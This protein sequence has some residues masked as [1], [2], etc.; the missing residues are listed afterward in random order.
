MRIPFVV[1]NTDTPSGGTLYDLRIDKA[2]TRTRTVP[3]PGT[4]PRP[5]PAAVRS[6]ERVL[7]AVPDGAPVLIDGLVACGVPEVVVARTRRL[8]VVVVVHL[9]L[10]R[11]SGLPADEARDLDA[12]ERRVLRACAGVV[13]TGAWAA[14]HLREHHDLRT[15]HV[16]PPGVDAAS[17]AGGG[18]PRP[19]GSAS[20][21]RLSCVASLTPR[22]GH[23]V[24]FQ[25]LE[26][27][28]DLDWTCVCVGPGTPLTPAPERVRFTGPLHGSDLDAAY[29]RTDLLVLPSLAETYGMVVTEA[30]ARG[31][32]VVASAV[33]GVPEALGQTPDHGVPG[34][35]VPAG[36]PEALSGALRAWLTD[37][38]LRRRLRV[39]AHARRAG[40]ADWSEAARALEE[41]LDR[42]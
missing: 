7:D 19:E 40:L 18:R 25:A 5:D 28:A 35:L 36:D 13:A 31:I 30:L 10:A 20:S 39:A 24:L 41:V 38:A 23:R 17:L 22:K 33:G 2:G 37:P 21:P 12:R 34:L 15:V 26:G 11:E 14:R 4:W 42:V 27:L 29:D 16:V 9:P 6:L 8:R 3:V 1:P 32:P